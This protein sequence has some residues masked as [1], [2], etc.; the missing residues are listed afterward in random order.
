MNR[1]PSPLMKSI[2]LPVLLSL[3]LAL[4]GAASAAPPASAYNRPQV[5]I[6]PPELVPPS[7]ALSPADELKTFHLAPGI[8]VELVASEPMV[9]RPVALQF[10]P[11]GRLWVVEM[12]AFMPN[13]EGTGEDNPIGRVSVLTDTD[14]DGR[15]DKSTVFLDGLVMPRA[16][17]LVRDGALIGAPP[18]LWFCRDTRGTGRAD[19]KIELAK[20]FGFAPDPKNIAMGEPENQPNNPLWGFDNWIHIGHYGGQFRWRD[21]QW[22]RGVANALG[23]WGLSQDDWGHLFN[24]SN[25]AQLGAQMIPA[26]YL[27]RNPHYPRPAGRS[28]N[29]AHD[30]FVWP[31]RVTPG[32]NRGYVP[33]MLRDN[34]LMEFTAACAPWIYRADLFPAEFLGN[35]FVCEPAGN[36][37]KRNIVTAAK[38]RLTAREAYDRSEFLASTD[39]R[40]RPVN[41]TTGPDGALY[42]CDM[43]HG[44]IE[45]RI[46]VSKYLEDQVRARGLDQPGAPQGRIWRIVPENAPRP[47]PP[48]M[49]QETP[50]QWVAHLSHR[51]AWWRETA[52]RL[53]VERGDLSVAPALEKLAAESTEPMARLHALWT[54]DGLRRTTWRVAG[55]ALEDADP[56]VRAA[57]LQISEGL[58]DGP[59]R[60]GVL[61]RWVALT[62]TESSP[63]VQLQLILSLGEARDPAADLAMAALARRAPE[64]AFLRDALLTGV[65]GREWDLAEALLAREPD[66]ADDAVLAALAGCILA[67]RNPERIERLLNAIAALPA[68]GLPRQVAL[69]NGLANTPVVTARRPMKLAAEPAAL[70]KL[71]QAPGRTL[72]TALAKASEVLTWPGK[73]GLAEEPVAPLTPEQQQRFD[74]GKQLFAATCA[75]CH[76]P[77]GLGLDGLA[78]PLVDSEWVNGPVERLARI[79]INGV[80]GPIQVGKARYRLDMPPWGA[81]DDSSLAAIFTYLR[82]EWGHTAA[83]VAPETIQRIRA[84]IADRHDAWTQAELLAIPAN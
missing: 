62:G 43:Y 61:A 41:M 77:H 52:Q 5:Q 4:A 73:P 11:D 12:R 47:A 18:Y 21:G 53:L 51:N 15:M 19:E 60:A 30:E 26:R 40:F 46:S 81:L 13:L 38:G 10:D 1:L 79:A 17:S 55:H 50:A 25:S 82:R 75:A 68:S 58:L 69:L 34:K 27:N 32:I 57:A 16:I 20:D 59:E 37:I 33:E 78:P 3:A 2:P 76:Q 7:P 31:A 65:G 14:G 29:V 42:V 8:R 63:E 9:E 36:L 24:N 45:H 35:A 39:E 6:I 83:P 49:S 66:P 84:A 54:L 22:E 48:R 56:R 64:S 70:A 72:Q 23:E 44:I 80:R 28:V 67:E 74:Q 71:Q